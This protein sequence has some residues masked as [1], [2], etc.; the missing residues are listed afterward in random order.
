MVGNNASVHIF[1][2]NNMASFLPDHSKSKAL[3]RFN[4]FASRYNW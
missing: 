2:K 1:P 3:Q 4:C